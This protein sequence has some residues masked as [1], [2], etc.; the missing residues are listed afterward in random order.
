[1]EVAAACTE[2]LVSSRDSPGF[3]PIRFP[4]SIVEEVARLAGSSP[5][6]TPR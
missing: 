1:M 4:D 3:V 5:D 2:S 6:A